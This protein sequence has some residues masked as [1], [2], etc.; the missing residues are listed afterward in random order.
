[1]YVLDSSALIEVIE[2]YETKERILRLI[3]DELLTVTS[4]T[5]HEALLGAVT[6]KQKNAVHA[7]LYNARILDHD[8]A[9]ARHGAIIEQELTRAGKK[10]NRFD[11]LIAAICQSH[12]AHLLT[13][14]ND[15]SKIKGLNVTVIK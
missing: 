4:I 14:D 9:A 12:N 11:V 7:A 15:F 5:V 10:I 8:E 1:M 13:L 3:P 2:D 6:E